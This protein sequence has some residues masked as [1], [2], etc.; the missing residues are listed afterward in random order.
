M[1]AMEAYFQRVVATRRFQKRREKFFETPYRSK[2]N[3]RERRARSAWAGRLTFGCEDQR[4]Y[5]GL[6]IRK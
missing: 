3:S 1:D 5:D 6:I 4:V 2:E